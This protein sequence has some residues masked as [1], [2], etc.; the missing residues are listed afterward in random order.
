MS[1]LC[2]NNG[3]RE[4][5]LIKRGHTCILPEVEIKV[6]EIWNQLREHVNHIKTPL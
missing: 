3:I 6:T 4:N 1:E 5:L 2:E